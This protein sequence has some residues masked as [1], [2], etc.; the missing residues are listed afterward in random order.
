MS[1][2]H[3]KLNWIGI[4]V[5]VGIWVGVT[6]GGSVG[7]GEG[8][9]SVATSSFGVAVGSG[10]VIGSGSA[11]GGDSAAGLQATNNIPINRTKYLVCIVLPP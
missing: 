11:V 8:G 1:S 2:Y 9:I 5:A 6:G 3:V 7:E 4:E 10:S